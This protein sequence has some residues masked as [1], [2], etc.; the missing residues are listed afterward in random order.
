MTVFS[1]LMNTARLNPD[2]EFYTPDLTVA[3]RLDRCAGAFA[4]ARVLC[5]C[6]DFRDG[7]PGAFARVLADRYDRLGLTRLTA[8]EYHPADL[9]DPTAHGFRW[10]WT[11]E[12]WEATDLIESG[13]FDTPEVAELRTRAD[14]VATNPPFSRFAEH[15]NTTLR[16]GCHILT[17]G[18]VNAATYLDVLPLLADDTLRVADT[19]GTERGYSISYDRPDGSVVR[20][21]NTIW[22]TDLTDDRPAAPRRF[23]VHMADRQWEFIDGTDTLV[24]PV[25]RDTPVDWP[26]VM[27]VSPSWIRLYDPAVFEILGIWNNP[28]IGGR[29]AFKR[30]LVRRRG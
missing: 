10:D 19:D 30:L 29:V 5:D 14:I 1:G 28:S 26:G 18:P 8:V 15:L 17:I 27:A 23:T 7:S 21:G 12:R 16:A 11:G 24:V 3:S 20:L 6:N 9:L 25:S 4:G 22:Y 13:G 2:D